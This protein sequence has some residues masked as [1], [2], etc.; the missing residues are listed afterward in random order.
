V[1]LPIVAIVGF[2][3]ARKLRQVRYTSKSDDTFPYFDSVFTP[4]AFSFGGD[5]PDFPTQLFLRTPTYA[6]FPSFR[7][8]SSVAVSP[9]PLAVAVSVAVMAAVAYLFCCLRL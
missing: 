7:C 4:N 2:F 6:Q 3:L 1:R 5:I 9:F 8:R